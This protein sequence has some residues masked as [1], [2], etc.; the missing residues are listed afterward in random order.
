MRRT[1]ERVMAILLLNDLGHPLRDIAQT[2]KLSTERVRQIILKEN[3]KP[4]H[5]KNK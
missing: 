5:T 3:T 1:Q 4:K 2:F